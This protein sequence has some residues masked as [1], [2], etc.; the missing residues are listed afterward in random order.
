MIEINL[1]QREKNILKRITA[2]GKEAARKIKRAQI[3]LLANKKKKTQEIAEILDIC[4]E[5]V[6]RTKKKYVEN[7]INYAINERERSGAPDGRA[8]I[9]TLACSKPP[10]GRAK[11]TLRLL[12][13]KISL[14][15]L[16]LQYM[17][18]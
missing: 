10:E 16:M 18:H 1:K 6:S 9:I 3:L 8:E 14:D 4:P 15:Y 7:G 5:T 17:K 2:Q 12:A 13:D 11:W